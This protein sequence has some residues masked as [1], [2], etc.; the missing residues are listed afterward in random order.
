MAPHLAPRKDFAKV[1][2]CR[3]RRRGIH[4]CEDSWLPEITVI[5][6]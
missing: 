3:E 4:S 2:E 1:D 5:L 6:R